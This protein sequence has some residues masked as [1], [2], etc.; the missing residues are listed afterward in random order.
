MGRV[1]DELYMKTLSEADCLVLPR[2]DN[3]I[4]RASFPTRLPEFLSTGKPVLTTN[5]PDVPLYL[6]ANKNAML[7]SGDSASALAEGIFELWSNPGKAKNIGLSGKKRGQLEFD[8]LN[9]SNSIY[10]FI[11]ENKN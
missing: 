3:Q 8:Y 1:P 11:Q 6:E 10:K 9:R 7:V 2:P 5:V 4:V